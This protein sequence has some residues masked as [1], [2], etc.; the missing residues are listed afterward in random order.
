MD[1][2]ELMF[3]LSHSGRLEALYLLSK[4]PQRLT[5]ISKA[6]GLTS[7]EISRHLGRLS[8]AQLITKDGKG[9][10]SLTLFG[11]IILQELSNLK[12]VTKNNQYFSTHDFSAIPN[13]ICW[14]NAMSNCKLVKGTLEIMSMVEDLSK[15][16][17]KHVYLISEQPM[18]TMV[19]INLKRAKKG[20]VFRLIY[21][22]GVDVPGEYRKKKGIPI[23]VGLV[24][25][26]LFG[27]KLNEKSGGIVVPDLNGKIDYG[28]ALVGINPQF[29][30]WL[31]ILFDN[32]WQKAELAF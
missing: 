20:I 5:D 6:L 31:N 9:Q 18:R 22:K 3:E 29:L 21:P 14:L 30:V 28:F 24:D 19:D 2:H 23:E 7:A 1:D 15:N 13:E 12:F 4:E 8:K 27:M 32:F 10:Y 16:A 17:N 25:E 26:V 11:K